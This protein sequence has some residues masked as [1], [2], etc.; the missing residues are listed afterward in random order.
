NDAA[1]NFAASTVG[2]SL[3]ATATT[4]RITVDGGIVIAAGGAVTLNIGWDGNGGEALIRG[5]IQTGGTAVQVN[6]GG[7]DD[8]LTIE[9]GTAVLPAAGVRFNGGGHGAI[10]PNDADP[11]DIFSIVG[12]SQPDVFCVNDVTGTVLWNGNPLASYV[13]VETLKFET[14]GGDDRVTF[15]IN[16]AKSTTVWVD[17]G[18]GV[19]GFRIIGSPGA[20]EIIALGF[21]AVPSGV[22]PDYADPTPNFGAFQKFYAQAVDMLEVLGEGGNDQIWNDMAVHSL[23]DCGDGDDIVVG[24]TLQDVIFGGDGVDKLYGR[25]GDDYLFADH[26]Y[27]G[28]VPVAHTRDGDFIWGG[29]GYDTLVALGSDTVNGG[30]VNNYIIGQGLHLT[31]LD[32]LMARFAKPTSGTVNG[33]LGEAL[34]LPWI[35]LFP[36]C[37]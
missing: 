19:D 35:L 21:G 26:E 25:D 6:G 33:L 1:I 37:S 5:T 4:G 20:D 18:G 2:G 17:A 29:A 23:L 8:V 10:D 12:T 32:W 14:L 7:G 28:G 24:G 22:F 34:A 30:G 11:G 31:T 16:G 27:N 13:N 36:N 15:H 9:L 3:T